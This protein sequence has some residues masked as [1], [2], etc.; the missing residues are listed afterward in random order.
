MKLGVGLS[1]V[2]SH[3]LVKDGPIANPAFTRLLMHF[4][5]G[6][7]DESLFSKAVTQISSPTLD[8]SKKALGL[9]SM[10]VSLGARTSLSSS[11]DWN[12]ADTIPW[13]F[14]MRLFSATGRSAAGYEAFCGTN[15]F[16]GAGFIFFT[17]NAWTTIDFGTNSANFGSWSYAFPL[18]TWVAL[19]M[20]HD[21]AG[22][23]R[24]YV[25]GTLIATK[26]IPGIVDSPTVPLFV[27]GRPDGGIPWTGNI[28]EVLWEKHPDLIITTASSYVVETLP[29]ATP[30]RLSAPVNPAS[31]AKL[32]L[33]LDTDF[34][35]SSPSAKTP[36][37]VNSPTISGVQKV[38]GAGSY[39]SNLTNSAHYPAG[40]DWNVGD[41]VPFQ[42]SFRLWRNAPGTEQEN[43]IGTNPVNT[44]GFLLWNRFALKQL[45][46]WSNSVKV[47]SFPYNFDFPASQWVAIRF[48][49]DGAGNYR[50]YLDGILLATLSASITDDI[51][52]NFYVGNRPLNNDQGWDGYIDELKWEKHA[53]LQITTVPAYT[54]ET[55]A[56]PNS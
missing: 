43:L 27:G 52:K 16:T 35:D 49:G 20:N 4:D 15:N 3:S 22:N 47:L 46:V 55:V 29:Y 30:V 11:I 6:F 5:S 24:L 54:L 51:T 23:Y 25:D 8:T 48:N 39:L 9:G 2:L 40:P 12:V 28:D 44:N 19:R 50:M 18:D 53:S 33:H 13:Q 26:S 21:G 37:L 1:P 10:A 34:S 56:F 17:N 41:S 38:F 14:S 36:T 32:L 7:S 45:N 42:V 31:M